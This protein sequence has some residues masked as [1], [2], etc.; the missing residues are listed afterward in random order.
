MRNV[1]IFGLCLGFIFSAPAAGA[2]D[3]AV[4][5]QVLA[6][7]NEARAEVG[8]PPLTLNSALTQAA[9][10][11]TEWRTQAGVITHT[12]P[13]GSTP[14]SRAQAAGYY[15]TYVGENIVEGGRMTPDAA[16]R[17][18]RGSPVHYAGMTASR[19]TDAGIGYTVTAD[20]YKRYT[21]LMGGG[22]V[23]RPSS[24]AGGSAAEPQEAAPVIMP[25]VVATPRPEDGAVVHVVEEGQALW[26]IAVVYEVEL[27]RLLAINGLR[28]GDPI[29]PGNEILV[30]PGQMTPSPRGPVVH[31][32]QPEESLWSI[33]ARYRIDLEDL[34]AFNTLE[35][36]D[37]I[38][39]GDEIIIRPA[40][41]TAAPRPSPTPTVLI[42][43]T[44]RRAA[45]AATSTPPP[46]ASAT[47]TPTPAAAAAP[48]DTGRST[49]LIAGVVLFG[50]AVAMTLV[51]TA[52]ERR[53]RQQ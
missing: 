25:V 9:Q 5:R 41:P 12:G 21:L 26:T 28:E 37:L 7:V 2:Q 3:A 32:V 27:D 20:G 1:L 6:L 42:S 14:R 15:K 13:G 44:P 46:A 19:Y 45:A 52:L 35:E 4:A 53:R 18:W 31:I 38:H 11:F 29:F 34:R 36:G 39:P 10:E 8:L 22:G 48:E 23:Q 24:G 16:V 17:W 51:G 47:P 33:A 49:A 30:D 50:L 43:A 40:D